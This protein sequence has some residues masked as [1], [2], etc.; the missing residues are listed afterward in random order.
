MQTCSLYGKLAGGQCKNSLLSMSWY[1]PSTAFQIGGL[2][3]VSSASALPKRA[4]RN[5][6]GSAARNTSTAR[7][8]SLRQ[9]IG[10]TG[11][12]PR[13]LIENYLKEGWQTIQIVNML[14][15]TPHN[16]D[17]IHILF[18]S[19]DHHHHHC[20]HFIIIIVGSSI[21]ICQVESSQINIESV[22]N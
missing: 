6:Q 2:L 7:R 1:C 4:R 5:S 16:T 20:D 15:E 8:R 10:K 3:Q 13:T 9:S 11:D 21:G 22:Q 12:T 17:S 18:T 14:H 19:H